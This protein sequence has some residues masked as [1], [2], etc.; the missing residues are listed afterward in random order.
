MRI[1]RT[2]IL[3]PALLAAA[4]AIGACGPSARDVVASSSA[5]TR[6]PIASAV[7]APVTTI[8]L[9]PPA[10]ADRNAPA[11]LGT[12]V[13]AAKGWVVTVNGAELNANATAAKGNQFNRPEVGKQYVA[14]DLTLRNDSELPGS[15]G[16]NMKLTL[17]AP[18]GVGSTFAFVAGVPALDLYSAQLQ[19]GASVTGRMWFMVPT[20]EAAG[21]VLLAEPLFTLDTVADQ[22]F[23]A[24]R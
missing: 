12:P 9:P 16:A 8:P 3:T 4:Y 10:G 13:S 2:L 14:V 22:R 23:L 7:E 5:T 19:P 11:P 21:V 1:V 24:V 20:A 6:A 18:S 17:L 15:P